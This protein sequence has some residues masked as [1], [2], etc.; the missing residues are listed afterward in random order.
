MDFDRD[1]FN[2]EYA[3]FAAY[4]K[5]IVE[6]ANKITKPHTAELE[7]CIEQVLQV[8][9]VNNGEEMDIKIDI[10]IKKE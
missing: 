4:T 5:Q 6:A 1:A 3:K 7:K 9:R 10:F 2:E 8:S